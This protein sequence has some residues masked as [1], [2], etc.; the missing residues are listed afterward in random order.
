MSTTSTVTLSQ[1]EVP[2]LMTLTM[3]FL[4]ILSRIK[5]RKQLLLLL[6]NLAAVLVEAATKIP[7][8]S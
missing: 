4:T 5:G 8:S 2:A 1:L 6:I 3:R 7:R